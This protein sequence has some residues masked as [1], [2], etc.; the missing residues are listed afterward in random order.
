[1]SVHPSSMTVEALRAEIKTLAFAPAITPA[2]SSRLD[3]L[4]VELEARQARAERI[5]AAKSSPGLTRDAGHDSPTFWKQAGTLDVFAAEARSAIEASD[6]A[7]RALEQVGNG[8]DLAPGVEQVIRRQSAHADRLRA[9]ADPAYLSGFAKLTLAGGDASRAM[10]SMSDDERAAFARVAEADKR[11]MTISPDTAGG[12]LLPTILDPAVLLTNAGESGSLRAISRMVTGVGETY[13]AITSAGSDAA[14]YGELAEVTDDSPVLAAVDVPARRGSVFVP[15]SMELFDDFE[16]LAVEMRKILADSQDRLLTDAFIN[17]NGT[18]QPA[19]LITRLDANTN[20][21]VL[22]STAGQLHAT[23]IYRVFSELP[24][25]HRSNATWLMSLDVMN[26][27]RS[28]GDDKLSQQTASM[29]D[30][31]TFPLLGRPVLESSAMPDWTGTTG[32]ANVLV[33]GDF[34]NYLIFERLGS[35]LEL[36]PQLFGTNGRPAGARGWFYNF[37]VGAEVVN[38]DGFRLLVNT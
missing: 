14:W 20:V 23:D 5:A 11:A 38:P 2:E 4:T 13:R 36:I 7:M 34:S 35:R 29:A 1:M 6:L 9:A 19:G 21:E 8:A 25:R 37:R 30:G 22:V 18:T 3:S 16:A 24:A 33:V 27:V 31:Y 26:E 32:A 28:L 12:Y 15:V 17:G 10:L